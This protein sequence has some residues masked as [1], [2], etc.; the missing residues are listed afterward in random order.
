VLAG[1]V[2]VGRRESMG[3]GLSGA[4]AVAERPAQLEA[5]VADPVGTLTD[6]A[7]RVAATW[8]PSR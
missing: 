6:R 8:S 5:A 4:Y 1:Q 2:L 7:A 3:L